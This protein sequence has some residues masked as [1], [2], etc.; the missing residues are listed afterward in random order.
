MEDKSTHILDMNERYK[1]LVPYL[2]TVSVD[3][4]RAQ[5]LITGELRPFEDVAIKKDQVWAS[6]VQSDNDAECVAIL[7]NISSAVCKALKDKVKDHLDDGR[8]TQYDETDRERLFFHITNSL[9]VSFGR[10]DW[11][12]RHRPNSSKLVNE[13]HSLH[14]EYNWTVAT[15]ARRKASHGTYQMVKG[16]IKICNRH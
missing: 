11:L 8:H 15:R 3:V 10:L 9:S 14:I 5:D 16:T 12:L 6:L 13:A 2:E 7:S 1:T 4:I